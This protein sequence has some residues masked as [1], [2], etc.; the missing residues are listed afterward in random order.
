MGSS[1]TQLVPG[2]FNGGSSRGWLIIRHPGPVSATDRADHDHPP[3]QGPLMDHCST[4]G[5]P[6]PRPYPAPR[7]RG[8]VRCRRARQSAPPSGPGPSNSRHRKVTLPDAP[9]PLL[10]QSQGVRLALWSPWRRPG[11]PGAPSS[12]GSPATH[13]RSRAGPDQKAASSPDR[14]GPTAEPCGLSTGR[15]LVAMIAALSDQSPAPLRSAGLDRLIPISGVT[16]G[17]MPQ[18]AV[19]VVTNG[20]GAVSDR[21]PTPRLDRPSEPSERPTRVVFHQPG[22]PFGVPGIALPGPTSLPSRLA[23]CFT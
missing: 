14:V 20:R 18:S 10:A 12:P 8:G 17:Q 4:S 15:V 5:A 22:P 7:L 16:S 23:R 6:R 11:R 21:G 1:S 2:S 13:H 19:K 3:S 9:T